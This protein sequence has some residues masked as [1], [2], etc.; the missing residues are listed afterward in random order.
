[1][2]ATQILKV[3]AQEVAD[4]AQQINNQKQQMEGYM[5]EMIQKVGQLGEAWKTP[6]GE[7]YIEKFQSVRQEIQDS[8]N[9]L[10]KHTDNLV[11]AAQT[12][13]SLEQSQQ[14]KVDSL[15]TENIF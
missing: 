14:Q 2:A 15:S 6:S 7:S 3:S 8:L 9:T 12:Y 13:D 1:M 5:Q 11:Q 4:K 10:Q